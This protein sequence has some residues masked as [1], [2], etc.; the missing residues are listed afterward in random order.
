VP[1]NLSSKSNRE[2]AVYVIVPLLVFQ[3]VLLS[4]QIQNPSGM[5]PIKTLFLA[6][7]APLVN[8]ASNVLAGIQNAWRGYFWLVDVRTDNERLEN[9]V[10]Q[11]E[12]LNS[13]LEEVKQEND[14][15]RHLL[16]IKNEAELKTI[17]A[18]VIARTP[19][20]LSNVLYINRGAS[21]GVTV[22][23]PVLA[24]H[25]IVGRIVLVAGGQSQVQLITNPD[26]SIGV[27]ME[28]TRTPGVLSGTG[29][30]HLELN[31]ISTTEEIRTGDVVLSSGLDGI[32][33]KGF[34]VGRVTESKKSEG[35]FYNIKVEP[36]ADLYHLEEV[37]V[38]LID[39]S[40]SGIIQVP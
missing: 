12:M 4:V 25:R 20:F 34:L 19:G 1:S 13:S 31:Y 10:R 23:S 16:S 3:L 37:S 40:R 24:G 26:A 21:H 36:A 9:R 15:L 33:P 27:M 8:V 32:F 11:L 30:S 38:L 22:D 7:Q 29:E 2:G 5:T 17:E 14:R 28:Q 35:I 6:V 39:P 18:R